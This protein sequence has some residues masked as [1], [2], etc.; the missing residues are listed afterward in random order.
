MISRVRAIILDGE[1]V[2]FGL[3]R[4]KDYMLPGGK[5][6]DQ[7][8]PVDA[9]L[10]EIKEETGIANFTKL[11]YLWN[12][13]NNKV[14]LFVPS[15]ESAPTVANDPDK[16]FTRLG[17]FPLNNLPKKMNVYTAK[18]MNQFL[19]GVTK[20]EATTEVW[21]DGEK[22]YEIF[23]DE[24]WETSPGLVQKR[25]NEGKEIIYR[26]VLPDG[27][28]VDKTPHAMPENFKV[29]AD[30]QRATQMK[31]IYDTIDELLT[32]YIPEESNRPTAEI[33]NDVKY[34]GKTTFKMLD[35]KAKTH[36]IVNHKIIEDS[37]LLRQVLAH[38]I[39]HHHLYQKYHS[40]VADHGEMF[41]IFASRINKK[42]G[43]NFVTEFANHTEFRKNGED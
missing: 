8:H 34:L 29:G 40:E 27:T 32:R 37:N 21:V 35:D 24:I 28:V 31:K 3:N 12:F 16:E 5:I 36:I 17:W 14:F 20:T 10:R 22:V 9:L 13:S 4:S 19:K 15:V 38:E 30:T 39:I 11:N 23:D 43:K 33:V 26:E 7:E 2:L 41:D 6:K 25:I 42:E 1:N 18:I